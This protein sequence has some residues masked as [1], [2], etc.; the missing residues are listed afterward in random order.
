MFYKLPRKNYQSIVVFLGGVDFLGYQLQLQQSL[1]I[2]GNTHARD[3]PLRSYVS[4]FHLLPYLN[5]IICMVFFLPKYLNPVFP[6]L[7]AILHNLHFCFLLCPHKQPKFLPCPPGLY[8]YCIFS[9]LALECRPRSAWAGTESGTSQHSQPFEEGCQSRN[10]ALWPSQATA[11][12]GSIRVL[13][14]DKLLES[15]LSLSSETSH[16]LIK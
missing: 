12:F 4:V 7:S 14:S 8:F 6:V 13:W 15:E 3:V 16:F 1:V 10:A 11:R 9:G 2:S 5:P